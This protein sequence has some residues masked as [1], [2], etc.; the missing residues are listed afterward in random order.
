MYLGIYIC[1]T[2]KGHEFER[3]Q[4]GFG[5]R[6]GDGENEVIILSKHYFK[7]AQQGD[8]SFK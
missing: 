2:K 3:E 7:V 1:I 4:G 8:A 6:K 5:E